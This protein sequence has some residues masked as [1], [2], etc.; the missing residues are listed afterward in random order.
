MQLNLFLSDA[1]H[2]ANKNLIERLSDNRKVGGNH[3]VIVPDRFTL[4]A[5]KDL[6]RE[7]NLAGSFDVTVTSFV[8]LSK[9]LLK[10]KAKKVLSSEGSVMLLSKV[11]AE[12]REDLTFYKK[13]SERSG[14]ASEIYA[15]ITNIR[16]NCYTVEDLK[17][18]VDD[19]PDYVKEKTKDIITLYEGYLK[20]L[21][22]GHLDGSTLLS[23]FS[24]LIPESDYI[25]ESDIY[26]FDYFSFT[27]EQRRAISALI[28]S[29]KSVNIAFL[30]VG[31]G[32]KNQR[33]YPEKEYI[34]LVNLAKDNAV[35][36]EIYE[37]HGEFDIGRKRVA[38]ELFSYGKKEKTT[39]GKGIVVFE[40][41]SAEEEIV[42]LARAIKKLVKEGYRYRDIAVLSGDV[43]GSKK[44]LKRVFSRHEIPYFADE[45][46][47]LSSTPLARYITALISA[48]IT[49]PDVWEGEEIASNPFSG[50]PYERVRGF[51]Q[52]VL[53]HSVS[54]MQEKSF[55]IGKTHENYED[56]DFVRSEVMKKIIRLS[57]VDKAKN[58]VEKIKNFIESDEIKA[59]NEILVQKMGKLQDEYAKTC[60][61]QSLVKLCSVLDQLQEILSDTEITREEFLSVFTSAINAVNVSYIP[62][63]VDSVYVGGAS[64]S[65]FTEGRVLFISS[66]QAGKL[67]LESARDG[68][69]GDD[70]ERALKRVNIDLSPTAVE[71]SY[72]EKTH[73]LQLMLMP[74][75]RLFISYVKSEECRPSDMVGDL[76]EMFSDIEVENAR[77]L[78]GEIAEKSE[79]GSD[80]AIDFLTSDTATAEYAYAF[81]QKEG[82][83][84]NSLK[85][86]L[87]REEEYADK[88]E[89]KDIPNAKE[90]F[91]PY[92]TSISQIGSYFRCP[93]AHYFERALGVRKIET[94]SSA[95]LAGSYIHAILEI[96]IGEWIKKGYPDTESQEFQDIVDN[97]SDIVDKME[98]FAPYLG[99]KYATVRRRLKKEGKESLRAVA[100]QAQT[101]D[102]K[103]KLVEYNFS[104]DDAYLEGAKVKIKL[105]GKI[106]RIDSY[107]DKS[108]LIDYKTGGYPEGAKD[109]YYG[110][111]V[112]LPVYMATLDKKGYDTRGAF[113]Y[114][115]SADYVK[116]DKKSPRLKGNIDGGEL[117]AFDKT[118]SFDTGSEYLELD[119]KE[120]K[121]GKAF[122][123]PGDQLV[124]DQETLRAIKEYAV[125]VCEKAVDE[126]AEGYIAPSPV[127]GV[128]EYCAYKILCED[129][130]VK[131][132]TQKSVKNADIVRIMSERCQDEVDE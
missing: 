117:S 110:K 80:R 49:K 52:Y 6:L 129:R 123:S 42:Y 108:V 46:T 58:H 13:A 63:F 96:G 93:Y 77:S 69:L 9:L 65:R 127:K 132:R 47:I 84:Y 106:D 56:A 91:F 14:F 95:S 73:L 122:R 131:T 90:V 124:C 70:E 48:S 113:Y 24:A 76:L 61:E 92:H 81:S 109:L 32:H 71:A 3:I 35:K 125:K 104:R 41:E 37:K 101:S 40:A 130:V 44:I 28:K 39:G 67:P 2:T 88:K 55:K 118:F 5:E 15:V 98:E 128:C 22:D 75:E 105:D 115:I 10:D 12:M 33:I 83:I 60:A 25:A 79:V 119:I 62:M 31:E 53:R 38:R 112:Q 30:R 97:T 74:K 7:L 1:L 103:P 86:I 16:N 8:R 78:W 21:S 100:K 57:P 85:S 51:S 107:E 66:A 111:G 72:E 89:V 19:L 20:A 23:E 121:G 102:Y 36:Y 29:A 94:G 82:E 18:S 11:I 126:M 26:L 54:Y 64:E 17:K 116:E 4:S 43:E 87:Q 114:P 99:E 27:A 120:V 59:K 68:I 45:K 50:I 34:R